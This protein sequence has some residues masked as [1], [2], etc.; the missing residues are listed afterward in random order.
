MFAGDEGA[1]QQ[2]DAQ[3]QQQQHKLVGGRKVPRGV[4]AAV[5]AAMEGDGGYAVT[6]FNM[7]QEREEGTIDEE[8]RPRAGGTPSLGLARGAARGVMTTPRPGPPAPCQDTHTHTHE[9]RTLETHTL[10]HTHPWRPRTRA[11]SCP[12]GRAATQRAAAAA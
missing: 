12:R 6:G 10:M 11:T 2:R 1:P 5:A 4:S 7:R 9:K 8:V 3:Q